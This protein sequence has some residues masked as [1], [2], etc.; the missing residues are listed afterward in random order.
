M[1]DQSALARRLG[2]RRPAAAGVRV[3]DWRRLYI[4][5]HPLAVTVAL[6]GTI[7]AAYFAVMPGVFNQTA[8]GQA[9]P[10][11]V[12]IGWLLAYG[13]GGALS[14]SGYWTLRSHFEAPGLVLQST[15]YAAYAIALLTQRPS[16]GAIGVVM[17]S[18]LAGGLGARALVI[19]TRPEVMPWD[20]RR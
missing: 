12:E 18:L 1:A 10:L 20:Q 13:I 3:Q 14:L 4:L 15:A 17:A 9:Y 8:I 2:D 5:Q 7:A 16:S 6:G 11:S 19:L